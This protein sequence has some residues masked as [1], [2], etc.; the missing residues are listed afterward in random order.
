MKKKNSCQ[1]I[2]SQMLPKAKGYVK[3]TKNLLKF[4]T[5]NNITVTEDQPGYS[6]FNGNLLSDKVDNIY[7]NSEITMKISQSI[8]DLFYKK[9]IRQ[10][11]NLT[12]LLKTFSSCI[13]P[14]LKEFCVGNKNISCS[15]YNSL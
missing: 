10:W 11:T 3:H 15:E 5:I 6:F 7:R 4:L 12:P 1:Q 8:S 13:D 9:G 14:M 2:T